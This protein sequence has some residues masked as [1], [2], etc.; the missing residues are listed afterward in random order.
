[1]YYDYFLNID[2]TVYSTQAKEKG[3]MEI[4]AIRLD[5]IKKILAVLFYQ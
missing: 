5:A 4:L 1:M 3:L 2:V